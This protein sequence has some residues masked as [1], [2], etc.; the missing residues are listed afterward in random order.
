MAK[1]R[2]TRNTIAA[3]PVMPEDSETDF[4]LGL[5]LFRGDPE[6]RNSYLLLPREEPEGDGD[7]DSESFT[8]SA[9]AAA[10]SS[11]DNPISLRPPRR[12]PSSVLSRLGLIDVE[13][14]QP[15]GL[16][17]SRNLP[18]FGN[19][20]F[21]RQPALGMASA[22][23]R[24]LKAEREARRE[25]RGEFE[26]VP[27]FPMSMPS[28]V[29]LDHVSATKGMAA[30]EDREWP[31]ESGVREAHRSG[32]RGAGV[33]VGV[34]DTGVDADHEEFGH[35]TIPFRYIPM[36]P[37]DVPPRDIRGFDTQG[38]GTHVCGILAGRTVGVAPEVSLSVASVIE[39]E[40]TRTSLIRVSYGLEWMLQQ[41]SRLHVDQLPAVVSL[42][43]GCNR[44][45]G[46]T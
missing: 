2:R 38:H 40:T 15:S 8:F 5:S 28:R 25:L 9:A 34:L 14:V 26:F 45:R 7:A 20:I 19:G 36:F 29:R 11:R 23:F 24:S 18:R 10:R 41:F 13:K 35:L 42:S 39:S 21:T 12:Y 37:R 44:S 16:P 32:V 6:F 27:N 30:L 4:D 46:G 31:V 43:L 33:L 17:Q 3:N 22:Y 1:K